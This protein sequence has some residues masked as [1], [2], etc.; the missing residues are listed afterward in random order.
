MAT[1]TKPMPLSDARGHYDAIVEEGFKRA[2]E[3]RRTGDAETAER[4]LIFH[5][6]QACNAF[7]RWLNKWVPPT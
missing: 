5:R 7:T 2:A 1:P 3:V 6:N 4:V